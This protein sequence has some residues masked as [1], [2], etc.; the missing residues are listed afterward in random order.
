[1]KINGALPG[2][3]ILHPDVSATTAF[4][5]RAP[6]ALACKGHTCQTTKPR[7]SA[8][9]R[10][11][12]YLT[13]LNADE[14]S[15]ITATANPGAMQDV[16][17]PVDAPLDRPEV[18]LVKVQGRSLRTWSFESP[19]TERVRVLL[20]TE[21]RP[22]NTNVDLWQ[23]PDNTPQKMA[24][25]VEDGEERPFNA[26]IETP[27]GQNTVSV[28]NTAEMEFPLY[29]RVEANAED[30]DYIKISDAGVPKVIQGGA[31][32]TYSFAPSV[33]SVQILLRTD[34]RPLNARIELL[35][36]PNNNKQIVELYTEDGLER[37]FYAVIESPGSG[38]V[39][40]VL[41]TAP[42]EFP[43]LA[44]VEPYL[45]AKG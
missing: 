3:C 25:Y 31:L 14:S 5:S 11:A 6:A 7:R 32:K 40:R 24:V 28:R 44:C 22:M 34:G 43:L 33:D 26:V 35:Q 30:A 41:N 16:I 2:L 8:A 18:A 4:I 10:T 20:T 13:R 9:L 15:E 1:M 23:G 19:V 38:N 17:Q 12:S 27:R 36:G 29:A 21:G 39:V 37:P 42:L 45:V